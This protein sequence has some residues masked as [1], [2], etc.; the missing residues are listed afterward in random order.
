M[1]SDS[2]EITPVPDRLVRY[3]WVRYLGEE[4]NSRKALNHLL[5]QLFP[6]LSPDDRAYAEGVFVDV[7]DAG[8][9]RHVDGAHRDHSDD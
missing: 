2:D 8:I 7:V 9:R 1:S 5:E 6:D 4:I 3:Q